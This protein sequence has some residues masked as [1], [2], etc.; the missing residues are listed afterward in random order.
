MRMSVEITAETIDV[1]RRNDAMRFDIEPYY[2]KLKAID[3]PEGLKEFF[4]SE[5][6]VGIRR[7]G[8]RC[9]VAEYLQ[10]GVGYQVLVGGDGS[11]Y[12]GDLLTRLFAATGAM[13]LF[14]HDFD[15]GCYPELEAA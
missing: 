1:Q 5:G 3:T 2:N 4:E 9:V 13:S 12:A 8:R 11:V 15:F 10:R 7:N 14:V 6:I